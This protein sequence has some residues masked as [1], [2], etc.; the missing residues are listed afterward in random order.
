M[1]FAGDT[2]I[3]I[4]KGVEK[5][6]RDL[7]Q[8]DDVLAAD[9]D[10][11]WQ[12]TIVQVSD[13]TSPGL[14]TCYFVRMENLAALVITADQPF[15]MPDGSVRDAQQLA[16]GDSVVGR[17]GEPIRIEYIA[18]GEY[19]TTICAIATS[20]DPAG[21]HLLIANGI[22]AGDFEMEVRPP[23]PPATIC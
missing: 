23:D 14:M 17:D 11:R 7:R 1:S 16:P 15:L 10:L 5:L 6:A 20:M 13:R 3:D 19:E 9:P 12:T 18:V 22:V 4:A 2:Q 21:P 8:G